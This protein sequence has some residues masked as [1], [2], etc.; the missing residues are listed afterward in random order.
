MQAIFRETYWLR[1]WALLQRDDETKESFR[2][3]SR[4]LETTML[5]LFAFHGWKFNNR[6]IIH[7]FYISCSLGSSTISSKLCNV[8][9]AVCGHAEAGSSRPFLF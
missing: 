8:V 6:L 1:F 7:D 3:A 2:L 4:K 9:I 5:E